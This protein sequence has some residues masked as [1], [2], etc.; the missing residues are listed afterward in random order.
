VAGSV[1]NGRI[2]PGGADFQIIRPNGIA[3]LA[4]RYVIEADDGALVYVENNGIRHGPPELMEM[5]RRGEAVDPTLIYFRTAPR[6]ETASPRLQF[7][8]RR[9]FIAVGARWPDRVTLAVWMVK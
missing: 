4:A 7:L 8:T 3:E 5:L 1:L 9:L 6:F 2:L